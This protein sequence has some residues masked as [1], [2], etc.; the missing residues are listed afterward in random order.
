MNIELQ[1][2]KRERQI[3][4]VLL[5]KTAISAAE[6]R[7]AMPSPPSDSAVRTHLRIL[8]RKGYARHQKEGNKYVYSATVSKNRAQKSAFQRI[9]RTFFGGSIDTAVTA[10][11]D[12]SDTRLSESELNKIQSIIDKANKRG[13]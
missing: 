9:L 8:V 2:S 1:L 4:E 12:A 5:A 11:L 7:S 3:M 10:L 6:I 13:K